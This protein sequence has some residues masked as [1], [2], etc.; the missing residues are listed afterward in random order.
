MNNQPTRETEIGRFIIVRRRQATRLVSAAV[1]LSI[2]SSARAQP[3][4]APPTSEVRGHREIVDVLF[5]AAAMGVVAGRADGYC[6]GTSFDVSPVFGHVALAAVLSIAGSPNSYERRH[7]EVEGIPKA[8]TTLQ[9]LKARADWHTGVEVVERDGT[10]ATGEIIDITDDAV[11]L[12]VKQD[13]HTV[14]QAAILEI[15]RVERDRIWDTPI[16]GAGVGAAWGL[17]WA[18]DCSEEDAVTV[19]PRGRM[20]LTGAIVVG[21]ATLIVDILHKKRTA[22]FRNGQMAG[23][24]HVRVSPATWPNGIGVSVS[25]PAEKMR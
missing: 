4:S 24:S 7:P 22:L 17:L 25:W 18:H 15:N 11:V 3:P 12:Q 23:T 14:A 20:M 10:V 8:A 1:I 6:G 21:L 5:L 9:D 16:L 2:A 13:R 19:P